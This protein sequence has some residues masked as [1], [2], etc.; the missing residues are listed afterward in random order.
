MAIQETVNHYSDVAGVIAILEVF[1]AWDPVRLLIV[2]VNEIEPNPIVKRIDPETWSRLWAETEKLERDWRLGAMLYVA[3]PPEVLNATTCIEPGC[4]DPARIDTRCLRHYR[5]WVTSVLNRH[6][7]GRNKQ[8]C[9]VSG[10][11]H[12]VA[13]RSLCARHYEQW[14][15]CIDA[16]APTFAPSCVVPDCIE[17]CKPKA[18]KKRCKPSDGASTLELH[19]LV[20]GCADLIYSRSL[21]TQHYKDWKAGIDLG[22]PPADQRNKMECSTSGCSERPEV[23][24]MCRYHY[25]A[26]LHKRQFGRVKCRACDRLAHTRG[27]CYS[28]YTQWRKGREFPGVGPYQRMTDN[29]TGEIMPRKYRKGTLCGVATCREPIRAKNLCSKHYAQ[30]HRHGGPYESILALNHIVFG[31][32][33]EQENY[34]YKIKLDDGTSREVT[35]TILGDWGIHFDSDALNNILTYRSTGEAVKTFGRVWTVAELKSLAKVFNAYFIDKGALDKETMEKILEI[36]I[37]SVEER[38]DPDSI[39]V[40]TDLKPLPLPVPEELLYHQFTSQKEIEALQ[41]L[42]PSDTMLMEKLLEEESQ[43]ISLKEAIDI[44][45]ANYQRVSSLL[46]TETDR[47][48]ISLLQEVSLLQKPTLWRRIVTFFKRLFQ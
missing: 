13:A 5:Q 31:A 19:C 36:F 11:I 47:D 40:E 8:Y 33:S 20:A 34:A 30:W 42:A 29:K 24:G 25:E 9:S 17:T 7:L 38:D 4:V 32:A 2:S 3:P 23:Q 37:Q 10:C 48:A 45:D 18:R 44:A 35:G 6:S 22:I 46:R 28:H 21:C 1:T 43:T 41:R 12:P 26:W 27:F 15:N 14:R 16:S 39:R